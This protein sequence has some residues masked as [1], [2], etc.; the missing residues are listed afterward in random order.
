[1]KTFKHPFEP[2]IFKD[3]KVMIIGTRPPIDADFYYSNNSNNRFWDILNAIIENSNILPKGGFSLS[4]NIKKEILEKLKISLADILE[5]YGLSDEHSPSDNV[6]NPI[7][8]RNIDELIK[9]TSITKLLFT[10]KKAA[11]LFLKNKEINIGKQN[12]EPGKMFYEYNI[13]NRNIKCYLLPNPLNRG[14]EGETLEKKLNIYKDLILWI[15]VWHTNTIMT[16]T[17]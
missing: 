4:K 2:I 11:E 14:R 10:Y 1:M 15:K 12:L 8:I 6:V 16:H 9:D 5:E 17:M 3:S 13:N 7:K